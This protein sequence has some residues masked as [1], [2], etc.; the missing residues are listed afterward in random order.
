MIL[1]L[2]LSIFFGYITLSL[3]YYI[4]ERFYDDREI[5]SAVRVF[6]VEREYPVEPFSGRVLDNFT[7]ALMLSEAI[8]YIEGK[9]PFEMAVETAYQ[10]VDELWGPMQAFIQLNTDESCEGTIIS[11]SRYWHGYL[12]FLKPLFAF[13]TFFQI[14]NINTYALFS[15]L[16][17]VI[18]LLYER[19][20]NLLL[21]F[22]VM[23]LYLAPTAVVNSLQYSSDCYLML[24]GI[25]L[26]LC[27]P[28]NIFQ[29]RNNVYILFLILGIWTSFLDLLSAPTISLTM[30]LYLVCSNLNEYDYSEND[31]WKMVVTCAGIWFAGYA[32]MWAGKWVIAL[33]VQ[34]QAF[35]DSLIYSIKF[36]SASVNEQGENIARLQG[37][38]KNIGTLFSI[39]YVNLVLVGTVCFYLRSIFVKKK[40]ETGT[41]RRTKIQLY[42]IPF[43]IPLIWMSVMSNHSYNHHWFTYRTLAP[44]VFCVMCVLSE[45]DQNG[46]LTVQKES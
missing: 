4:P 37:L 41:A 29:D 30:P 28:H 8:T 25:M 15:L 35:Y 32:V 16:M 2:I 22:L 39:K 10:G 5:S 12:L 23:I 19:K 43:I 40:T 44:C 27:N 17:A 13:F 42:L 1:I 21:P 45:V 38:T 3:T 14:R 31:S 18:M 7:D 26:F 36:R 34:K 9:T 11:Y 6:S 24:V 33:C 46:M 20:R